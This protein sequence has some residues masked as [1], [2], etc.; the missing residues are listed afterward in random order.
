MNPRNLYAAAAAS[1]LVC[2]ATQQIAAQ[3]PAQPN[4]ETLFRQR[5]AT[6]HAVTA[7]KRVAT[8]PNLYGVVGRKAA[9]AP[10][11]YNYSPALKKSGLVWTRQNLDAYLAAPTKKVPGTKMVISLAAP[12]QRAAI[13]DYLARVK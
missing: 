1:L 11:P 4:G 13:L 7:G 10:V 2:G 9:S 6:C 3:A 12:A 5:C 8:G